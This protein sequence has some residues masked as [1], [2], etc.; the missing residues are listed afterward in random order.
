M[1]EVKNQDNKRIV[2]KSQANEI[3][4]ELNIPFSLEAY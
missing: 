3:K 1:S 2:C 4:K